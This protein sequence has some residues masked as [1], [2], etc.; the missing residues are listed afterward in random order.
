MVNKITD[1]DRA[2]LTDYFVASFDQLNAVGVTTAVKVHGLETHM[3][4]VTVADIDT[5]VVVRF[6]GSLDGTNYGNISASGTDET[7]TTNGTYLYSR[8]KFPLEY[9][10]V[11]FV[12]E[13]GSTSPTIDVSYAGRL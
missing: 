13:E 4:Q 11:R 7:I 12:S 5:N 10:R 2:G 1:A 6:E 9:V 8:S 3:F